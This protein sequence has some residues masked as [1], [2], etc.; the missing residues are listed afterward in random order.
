VY[1]QIRQDAKGR[2]VG[3]A[4]VEVRLDSGAYRGALRWLLTTKIEESVG[5]VQTDSIVLAPTTLK[6]LQRRVHAGGTS[7]FFRYTPRQVLATD[8][9]PRLFFEE[10]FDTRASL[11]DSKRTSGRGFWYSVRPVD[12]HA[13]LVLSESHLAL[14]LRTVPL[15]VG[16]EMPVVFFDNS[17]S[18]FD[19]PQPL[20][21]RVTKL[22]TLLFQNA[23]TPCVRVEVDYGRRPDVWWV[24]MSDGELLRSSRSV[25]P[26]ATSELTTLEV[27][28][29]G[30]P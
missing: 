29:R 18:T 5:G 26:S 10:E 3:R 7:R 24:R 22:D 4:R 6:P 19:G 23:Q 28:P 11:W 30:R 25:S 2:T 9:L 12:A 15:T 13:A 14:L 8:T 1:S 21:L 16:L 20:Q 27:T 17:T